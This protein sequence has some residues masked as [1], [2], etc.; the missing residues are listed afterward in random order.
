MAKSLSQ[1]PP[2]SKLFEALA[3]LKNQWPRLIGY[4]D[5]GRYPIDNNAAERAIRPFTI[6]RKNWTFSQSQA[7]ARASANLYSLIE[8]A[9]ANGVNPQEYLREVF[10]R[11]PNMTTKDDL[12]ELLPWNLMKS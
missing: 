5:D 7:G 8:T 3:Y 4:L 11:L 12:D 6:G 1:V 9:K 2:S 10:T